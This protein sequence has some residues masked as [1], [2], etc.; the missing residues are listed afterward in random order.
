MV[1][2]I[3]TRFDCVSS[4]QTTQRRKLFARARYDE[5]KI[6]IDIVVVCLQ[7]SNVT[8]VPLGYAKMS[9]FYI[10]IYIYI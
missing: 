3:S 4:G 2:V 5:C 8:C 9:D 10:C 7:R 1:V 6:I